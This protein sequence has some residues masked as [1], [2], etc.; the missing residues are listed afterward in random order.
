[1]RSSSTLLKLQGE[2]SIEY[3]KGDLGEGEEESSE[4]KIES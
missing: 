4:M 2:T 3:V 1:M